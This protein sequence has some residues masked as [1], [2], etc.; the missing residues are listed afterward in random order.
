MDEK[1]KKAIEDL[2]NLKYVSGIFLFGSSEQEN[3]I[4]EF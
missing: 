1:L 4:P 3:S 2:S